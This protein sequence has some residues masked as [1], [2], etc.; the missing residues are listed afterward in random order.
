MILLF[1]VSCLHSIVGNV[2]MELYQYTSDP[3]SIPVLGDSN[4][5][6]LLAADSCFSVSEGSLMVRDPSGGGASLE[7]GTHM[8]YR[9][10]TGK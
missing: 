2:G 3:R 4:G 6:K 5:V 9:V 7:V 8:Q 10:N 1:L